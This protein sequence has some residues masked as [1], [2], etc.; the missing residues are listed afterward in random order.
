MWIQLLFAA[1]LGVL[2]LSNIWL[3][4]ELDVIKR[5]LDAY[6]RE[7]ASLDDRVC[8]LMVSVEESECAAGPRATAVA[9]D[10]QAG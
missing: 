3:L 4:R 6:Q 9:G 2:L 7:V 10:E 5:Q 1:G 8:E